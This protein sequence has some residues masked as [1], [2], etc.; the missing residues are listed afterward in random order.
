MLRSFV[1]AAVVV[2]VLFGAKQA[3]AITATST[4]YSPCDSSSMTSSGQTARVGYVAANGLP[5]GSWIE[6]RRPRLVMGRRFFR[7]MDR[8]GMGDPM[9]IDF[10]GSCSFME[11]WGRRTITYRPVPRSE[12]YRGLP[13]GGW[14]LSP[15][16]HHGRLTWGPR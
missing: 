12:L 8:G 1:I 4:V 5:M 13:I 3:F 9:A 15:G 16:K 6:M 11:S 14:R 7:V 2:G 10:W